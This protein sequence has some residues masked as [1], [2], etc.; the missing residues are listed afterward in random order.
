L[1]RVLT[2][3]HGQVSK[4]GAAGITVLL[5]VF[6]VRGKKVPVEEFQDLIMVRISGMHSFSFTIRRVFAAVW[7]HGGGLGATDASQPVAVHAS[8]VSDRSRRRFP[9]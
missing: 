1:I 7:S 4:S 8:G 3:I 9:S 5:R 6:R 2:G